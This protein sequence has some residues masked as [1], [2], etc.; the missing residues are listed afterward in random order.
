M[1]PPLTIRGSDAP[2]VALFHG[3][4][5]CSRSHYA[6]ALMAEAA[7]ARLAR[8]RRPFPR[9]QR[10]AQPPAARLPLGRQRRDRLDAAPAARA[11]RAPAL[12]C[13]RLAR[14]Q[15]AAEMAGRAGDAARKVG[16]PRAAAVSAPIDLMAA[17]DALG[18]RLQS[19]ST[20]ARFLGTLKRKSLAKLARHPRTL[21]PAAQCAARARCAR[22]T[23]RDRAAA[24]LSRHRRLLDAREQQAVAA[25]HRRADADAERA[26]RSVSARSS[27]PRAGRSLAAVTLEFPDEG[28]PRRLRHR[29]VSR[30]TRRGCPRRLLAFFR[31]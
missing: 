27:S 9:L 1:P 10:R 22:S 6:R 11:A 3:L 16:Q 23:T 13:R 12:R 30:V 2:L 14:R 21:R 18:P 17:G 26:Q 24:R 4:E 20:R 19:A 31:H 7:R 8:R 25:R 28:R 29:P 5:G 15:C